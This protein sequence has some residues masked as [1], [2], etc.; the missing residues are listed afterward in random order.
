MQEYE[1]AVIFRLGRL[2]SGGAKG[3]GGN[4][5]HYDQDDDAQYDHDHEDDHRIDQ[6]DDA[7]NDHD[8]D[9]SLDYPEDRV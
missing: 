9:D 6:C 8:G 7:P 1:R 3:P 4:D 2:L 5:H